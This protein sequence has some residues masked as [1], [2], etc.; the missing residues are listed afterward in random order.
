MVADTAELMGIDH[1]GMGTDLC[2]AQP[3]SVLTW[4]R[5]GR[6]TKAMDYG[7]GSQSNAGWPSP[8]AWFSD[9]R[10]FP[11]IVEGLR[12]KGFNHEEIGKIMGRNW[13]KQLTEGTRSA[14][15]AAF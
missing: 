11:N 13:L 2:Q 5:N 14:V 6:W 3:E 10:H 15:N 9:N 7:E 12:Q 8:L 4:M 1:I